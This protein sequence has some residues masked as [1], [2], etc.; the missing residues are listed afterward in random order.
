MMIKK[1]AV[2]AAFAASMMVGVPTAS[3]NSPLICMSEYEADLAGCGQNSTC[4]QYANIK[5]QQ[6]LEKLAVILE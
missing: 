2:A 6:C 5:F 1:L 4:S 3:A